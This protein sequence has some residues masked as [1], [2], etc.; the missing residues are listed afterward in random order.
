MLDAAQATLLML[1]T[2]ESDFEVFNVGGD[3][4]VTVLQYARLVT[5]AA[6]VGAEPSIPG[7]YRYGDTRHV[8]SSVRKLKALGWQPE[9]AM[10]AIV[11]DYLE[12]ATAQPDFRDYSSDADR[13]M[14]SLG[15]LRQAAEA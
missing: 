14:L 4:A 15:T 11:H 9:V 8:V 5:E 12:W 3:R 6:G 2:D 1:E 7:I 13:E 10:E